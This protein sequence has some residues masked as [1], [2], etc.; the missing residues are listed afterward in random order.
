MS[1][2]ANSM[3]YDCLLHELQMTK[4][5]LIAAS[6]CVRRG[7][8]TS[9]L[10]RSSERT[11]RGCQSAGPESRFDLARFFDARDERAGSAAHDLSINAIGSDDPLQVA[12]R[13]GHGNGG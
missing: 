4:G 10:R 7:W 13:Q 5:V 6:Q 9:S 12:L 3:V 11:G 1:F 2:G 8:S